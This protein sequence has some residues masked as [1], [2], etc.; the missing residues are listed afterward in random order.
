MKP[1]EYLRDGCKKYFQ[2]HRFLKMTYCLAVFPIGCV[3]CDNTVSWEATVS[4]KRVS[5]VF[6]VTH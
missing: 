1:P 3:K 4:V 5:A 6:S 2:Y